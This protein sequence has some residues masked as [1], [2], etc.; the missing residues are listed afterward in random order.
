MS[1]QPMSRQPLSRQP[2]SRQP[3]PLTFPQGAPDARIP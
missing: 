3:M 2:L 1:H